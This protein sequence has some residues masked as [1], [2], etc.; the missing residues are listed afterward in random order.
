MHDLAIAARASCQTHSIHL[1]HRCKCDR[2][3]PKAPK[4][5]YC[6]SHSFWIFAV[7]PFGLVVCWY[8]SAGAIASGCQPI[9]NGR[10]ELSL[11]DRLGAQFDDRKRVST[12][13]SEHKIITFCGTLCDYHCAID[14]LATQSSNNC[15]NRTNNQSVLECAQCI[16]PPPTIKLQMSL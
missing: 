3:L 5:E 13:P 10:E 2:T 16:R 9:V 6:C 12:L 14:I 4:A 8:F 7:L 1:T 15:W 11:R